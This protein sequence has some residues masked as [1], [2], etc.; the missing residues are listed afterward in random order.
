MP[1]YVQNVFGLQQMEKAPFYKSVENRW[2][3]KVAVTVRYPHEEE[4]LKKEHRVDIIYDAY[5]RAGIAYARYVIDEL[6]Y[7]RE[8]DRSNS[9]LETGTSSRCKC[10]QQVEPVWNE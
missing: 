3:G 2:L 7:G 8:R 1:K 4:K 10:T 9:S 6:K 5:D